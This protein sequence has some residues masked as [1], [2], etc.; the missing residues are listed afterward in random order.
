MKVQFVSYVFAGICLAGCATSQ[1]RQT[2]DIFGVAGGLAVQEKKRSPSTSNDSFIPPEG[3]FEDIKNHAEQKHYLGYDIVA[4]FDE[5][6]RELKLGGTFHYS[7]GYELFMNY[8]GGRMEIGKFSRD[9]ANP[10]LYASGRLVF[11]T[12]P[13]EQKGGL[14][15][16]I[17]TVSDTSTGRKSYDHKCFIQESNLETP[18]R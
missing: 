16:F 7:A 10:N 9:T 13:R 6:T 11:E 4:C 1:Q 12:G 5:Q 3:V 15:V 8:A 14:T 2:V 17:A 18:S